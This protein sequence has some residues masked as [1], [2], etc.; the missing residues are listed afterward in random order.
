M[1]SDN[2]RIFVVDAKE[3]CNFLKQQNKS[4]SEFATQERINFKFIPATLSTLV[5]YERPGLNPQNITFNE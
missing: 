2:G 5:E 4:L 1:C 3:L